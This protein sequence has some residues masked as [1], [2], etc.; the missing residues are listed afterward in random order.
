MVFRF[1]RRRVWPREQDAGRQIARQ[2]SG[3][4]LR[5]SVKGHGEKKRLTWLTSPRLSQVGTDSAVVCL[6][7]DQRRD[8]SNSGGESAFQQRDYYREG[9][10]SQAPNAGEEGWVP[11]DLHSFPPAVHYQL[12]NSRALA[13]GPDE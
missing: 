4:R 1:H 11:I 2:G 12:D 6:V 5:G 9:I 8:D 7:H 10:C 13:G 3:R